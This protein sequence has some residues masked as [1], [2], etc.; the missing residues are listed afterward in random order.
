MIKQQPKQRLDLSIQ[1]EYPALQT[2]VYHSKK[3]N[4]LFGPVFSELTRQLLE[5]IDS[6]RFMFYT[7]K[8]PTQ[9]EELSIVSSSWIVGKFGRDDQKKFQLSR[10]SRGC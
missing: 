9:I 3:I 1:T 4:A 10:I 2:I 6:S 7:R 5:T 8:T